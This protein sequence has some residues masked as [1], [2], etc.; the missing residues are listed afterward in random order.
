MHKMLMEI[1]KDKV[2][3]RVNAKEQE[4]LTTSIRNL[5]RNLSMTA[6]QAMEALNIPEAQRSIYASLVEKSA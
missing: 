4:T 5:M 1:V 3:E 6:E 2:E